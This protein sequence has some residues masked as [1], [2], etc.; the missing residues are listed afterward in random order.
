MR[1]RRSLYDLRG[2]AL[3]RGARGRPRPRRRPVPADRSARAR[4]SGGSGPSR[5][6]RVG[7]TPGLPVV[8]G[9]A[10]SQACALGA[11]VVAPGPVSEMAGSSTCLNAAV[12]APLDVLAVTHYPHVV[13]GR[14]HDGD[15]ASTRPARRSP[16]WPG[17]P[18]GARRGRAA[19]ADYARLDAR[20]RRPAGADGVVVLPV[21]GDGERTDPELRG[22]IA[23][24]SLR[25]ERAALARAV[26]EGVAFAIRDQLELLRTGGAPSRRSCA[27]PAATP[28]LAIVEP[29][30]GGRPRDAGPDGPR[31]RRGDRRRDAGRTRRRGLSR[32]WPTRSP[33]VSASD[34]RSSRIP[35][36]AAAYD[37]ALGGVPRAARGVV[38]VGPSGAAGRET[39]RGCGSGSTPASRSSAGRGPEDWAPMVRERLGL[40][41]RP[42]LARSRRPSAAD[43][44]ARCAG[45]TPGRRRR[46]AS[47]LHSTFTGLAAYSPN[48]LLDPE[49]PARAAA[50][51]WFGWAIALDGARRRRRDGRPRRARSR[52]GLGRPGRRAARWRG[53]PA[54][55][56]RPGR[57][58]ARAAG[59]EYL[60]VENLAA[61]REPST[62]AM[63]RRPAHDGDDD[64][65]ADP[66]VPRRRAHVRAGDAGR[67]PR[68]V[69]LAAPARPRPRRSIQL[70][71]SDAEGDH[72]WPFTAERNAAGRIDADRVLEALGE[73]GVDEAVLIL[74]VIPPFE[75]DDAAVVDDLVDRS[76]TGARRSC[77]TGSAT[78][79]N[80]PG[81][82]RST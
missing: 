41:A 13:A 67:R 15:R 49:A 82:T 37:D 64:A 31:R 46:Q 48:L 29:D 3:G 65:V 52:R 24:L 58:A 73:S 76:P 20:R 18:T 6:A 38:R 45:P 5:A 81:A 35:A 22:A 32:T 80:R 4:S 27:C 71:Q 33:D 77:G 44:S 69:R 62:M 66:A 63:I 56:R 28:R 78:A 61:A 75:Q 74:E 79:L 39:D 14:V 55:A 17:S 60:I 40:G 12:A 59:L 53:A 1:R 19:P 9:G 70:Q 10:D 7:L 21:L 34:R 72:H 57:D 51:A 50:V 16:G 23:G 68:P 8:I 42:A 26:L 47:S 43:G 11:G 54:I 30:Q 2:A 25:H 36:T